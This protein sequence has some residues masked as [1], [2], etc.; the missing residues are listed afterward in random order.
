MTPLEIAAMRYRILL[1]VL[2]RQQRTRNCDCKVC[3]M[4]TILEDNDER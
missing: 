3:E 1:D 2:K 4:I